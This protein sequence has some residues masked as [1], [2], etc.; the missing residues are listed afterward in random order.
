[1]IVNIGTKKQNRT[2]S[3]SHHIN[4]ETLFSIEDMIGSRLL[5][6]ISQGSARSRI[7]G[8]RHERRG[9]IAPQRDNRA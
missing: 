4:A 8:I 5:E 3:H 2:N 7:A 1:M 6:R 9:Y